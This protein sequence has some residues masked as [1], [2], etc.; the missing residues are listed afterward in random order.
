MIIQIN[1]IY[2]CCIDLRVWAWLYGSDDQRTILTTIDRGSVVEIAYLLDR[3]VGLV[4]QIQDRQMAALVKYDD[5]KKF[6]R[7]FV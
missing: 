5:L 2:I 1:E 3:L 4:F 6:F 7:R